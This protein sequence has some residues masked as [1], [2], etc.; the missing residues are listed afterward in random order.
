M[1]QAHMCHHQPHIHHRFTALDHCITMCQG[2]LV[3]IHVWDC[4]ESTQEETGPK[5]RL[6]GY[7]TSLGN[8]QM[9]PDNL[10]KL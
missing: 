5:R 6:R 2:A 8:S 4:E 9:Q 1:H 10:S 7:E 3:H